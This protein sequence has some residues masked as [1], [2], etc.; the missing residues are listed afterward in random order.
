MELLLLPKLI[1]HTIISNKS[2][3][4]FYMSTGYMSPCKTTI[5]SRA[6]RFYFYIFDFTRHMFENE[7][8]AILFIISICMNIPYWNVNSFYI[9]RIIICTGPTFNTHLVIVISFGT[10]TYNIPCKYQTH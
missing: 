5:Q 3:Q 4:K 6:T 8:I 9:N 1:S 10:Y 2:K 7:G